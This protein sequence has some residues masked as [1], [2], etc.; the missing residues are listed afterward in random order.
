MIH[1]G[2]PLIHYAHQSRVVAV[3]DTVAQFLPTKE[4]VIGGSCGSRTTKR[5]YKVCGLPNAAMWMIMMMMMMM[6]APPQGPKPRGSPR[7]T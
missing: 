2:Y 4:V 7:G 6:M 1:D 3:A 5:R